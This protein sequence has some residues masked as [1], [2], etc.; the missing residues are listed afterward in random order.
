MCLPAAALP[1]VAA[2]MQAA[3][4]LYG[5]MQANSQ[6]KYESEI[7]KQNAQMEIDAARESIAIGKDEARDYWRD[8]SQA[9]GQQ[10][11]SMA[12]NGI[13]VGF[14]TAVRVQDDTQMH[15]NEDASNLYRNIHQRTQGKL[16]TASNYVSEAKAARQRGK[17]ALVG[18][19]FQA[20][21]S[22]M[23]GF[24]QFRKA[25]AGMGTSTAGN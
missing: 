8:V 6:G 4:S 13:D 18:S 7:A 19:A 12:A 20:G 22:L 16:I 17:A 25:K 11:A 21:S 15:A 2:G 10:I 5:G 9:K 14:G 3:G 1:L 24:Q 23:S